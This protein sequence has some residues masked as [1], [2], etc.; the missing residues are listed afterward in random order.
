MPLSRVPVKRVN[1]SGLAVTGGH[2]I[3][4]DF[5]HL[6]SPIKSACCRARLEALDALMECNSAVPPILLKHPRANRLRR[7][8]DVQTCVL[9]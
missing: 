7:I 1:H 2:V 9:T 4:G 3:S 5:L 8:E 6:T